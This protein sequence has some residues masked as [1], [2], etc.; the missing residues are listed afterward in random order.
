MK[1]FE[2]LKIKFEHP[3]WGKDTELG[4]VDAILEN[5]PHFYKLLRD[6]IESGD[7]NSPFGRKE[8]P[9]I[10]QV[11]RA[12]IYKELKGLDYRKLEYHQSDS[13]I[14][15]LFLKLD[16]LRPYSFQMYQKY[17]SRIREESLQKLLFEINK[18][19]IGQGL[20]VL[21]SFRQ[22]STV[23]ETNIHYP[24]N[25]ALVW[26]CIK[27]ANRLLEHLNKECGDLDYMDYSVKAKKHYFNLNVGKSKD[28]RAILFR[29]QLILVVKTINQ[30]SNVIKKKPGSNPRAKIILAHISNHI[31][32]MELVEY[33]VREKEINGNKVPNEKKIFSIYEQ[34][35]DIIVKGG[36]RPEFG[37][38][39]NLGSG[40]SNLILACD[41]QRGNPS[42]TNLFGQMLDQII[43]EYGIT[44]RDSVTDGGYASLKNVGK[45]KEK[46]ISNVVFN[47]IVGSLRNIASSKNME[48]RL[49]KWRSGI[50]GI[51][52]NLKRRFKIRRCDWKG[53]EHFKAKVLWSVIGH[54]IRVMTALV[55][56]EIQ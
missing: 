10:E 23:V 21:K 9:S 26:D 11:V 5:N 25:N 50:E 40:R 49:K 13:R 17:I 12:A 14:C 19:A 47:K 56:K 24:T 8:T 37:H 33:M 48:T 52:S 16:E 30:L 6:D 45:A 55:L 51:I 3:N 39:I 35:T 22:D 31:K 53:W 36:R 15:S 44:P 4:L 27:E 43:E 29:K 54:N 2:E 20:E 1:L 42:D 28:K 41:I 18:I 38:K 34:H 46:G 32:V 7:K